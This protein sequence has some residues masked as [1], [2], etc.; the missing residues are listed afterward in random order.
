MTWKSKIL[1]I[2]LTNIA[3]I[4]I[5]VLCLNIFY[6]PSMNAPEQEAHVEIAGKRIYENNEGYITFFISFKFYDGSIREIDEGRD[7]VSDNKRGI[8]YNSIHEGETGI[9]TYKE[10]GRFISFNKDLKYGGEK[11]E[12]YQIPENRAVVLLIGITSIALILFTIFVIFVSETLY[13]IKVQA[14]LLE[15]GKYNVES[16]E[17]SYTLKY[18]TFKLADETRIKLIVPRKKVHNSL[19]KNESGMLTYIKSHIHDGYKLVEFESSRNE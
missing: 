9:L 10:N 6:F 4:A 17:N 11:I 8:I 15:K 1:T 12:S 18:A 14:T 16:E 7:G 2:I 13:Q 3:I 5:L 19:H